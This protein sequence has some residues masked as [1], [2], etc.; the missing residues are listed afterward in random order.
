MTRLRQAR[1]ADAAAIANVHVA[2]WQDAYAGILPNESLANMSD[3]RYAAMW[4]EAIA[5]PNDQAILVAEAADRRV[6]GF[7]S[8]GPNRNQ[9]QPFAGEVYTLYVAVDDQNQGIGRLLLRGLLQA[10][11]DQELDSAIVWVLSRNPS[12]FFYE[13][14][15]GRPAGERSERFWGVELTETA[16]GWTNLRQTLA[17]EPGL[18]VS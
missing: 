2:T 14:L 12:R 1:A 6:L 16:Y 10:L 9:H 7:G 8:A 15:G 3:I 18:Q 13:A 11:S 17:T 4:T 5:R